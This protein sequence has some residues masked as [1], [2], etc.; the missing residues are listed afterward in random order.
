MTRAIAFASFLLLLPL[1]YWDGYLTQN[2]NTVLEALL[3]DPRGLVLDI[4]FGFGLSFIIG[5]IGWFVC[6]A[7]N[8]VMRKLA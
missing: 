4:V 5:H 3:H 1:L 7:F 8:F 6:R 2:G